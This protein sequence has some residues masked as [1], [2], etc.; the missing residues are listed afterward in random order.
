MQMQEGTIGKRYDARATAVYEVDIVDDN[1]IV[2]FALQN[3]AGSLGVPCEH[4]HEELGCYYA[5][6][7]VQLI[8][9]V[10]SWAIEQLVGG[11]AKLPHQLV[12]MTGISLVPVVPEAFRDSSNH[13]PRSGKLGVPFWNPQLS[14]EALDGLGFCQ[15][16]LRSEGCPRRKTAAGES[17][18][19]LPQ[20][21][22]YVN[23]VL[24]S[25]AECRLNSA[26]RSPPRSRRAA[27]HTKS[28][29]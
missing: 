22:D 7:I 1:G 17:L 28:S 11:G 5:S 10:M 19:T 29:A 12:G 8:R 26:D 6:S 4:I 14:L 3:L 15:V 20:H 21:R 9:G 16:L 13:R 25:G 27:A 23:Y 2:G 24:G 18:P